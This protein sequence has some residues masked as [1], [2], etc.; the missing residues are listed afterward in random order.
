MMTQIEFKYLILDGDEV[1]FESTAQAHLTKKEIKETEE[2][3]VGHSYSPE[4]VDI[5]TRVHEKCME[6]AFE[7]AMNEYPEI[8]ERYEELEVTLEQ[9][10]PVNFIMLFSDELKLK[11]LTDD[12]YYMDESDIFP[13]TKEEQL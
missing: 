2:F 1:V 10:L 13:A 7:K 3:I 8:Q 4:F 5:P 11:M 9:Y 6:K 12:P